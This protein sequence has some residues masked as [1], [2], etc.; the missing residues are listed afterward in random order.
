[1]VDYVEFPVDL[2]RKIVLPKKPDGGG[3]GPPDPTAC[4]SYGP[5]GY[6]AIT[7]RSGFVAGGGQDTITD[8]PYGPYQL[9]PFVGGITDARGNVVAQAV[10]SGQHA[11]GMTLNPSTIEFS[12]NQIRELAFNIPTM[13]AF[14]TVPMGVNLSGYRIDIQWSTSAGIQSN[15]PLPGNPLYG[16]DVLEVLTNPGPVGPDT[17]PEIIMGIAGG[18]PGS[19]S[20]TYDLKNGPAVLLW[21][22]NDYP[23]Y[24]LHWFNGR[25]AGHNLF[26]GDW[27]TWVI[28]G[29]CG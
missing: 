11:D 1:M 15:P 5:Y 6:G 27:Y 26:I 17:Q 23:F 3:G 19:F 21:R 9:P 10:E 12:D 8:F 25:F 28:T 20:Y 22:W 16:L 18:G 29:L 13:P 24:P 4:V 2:L 7:A 14:W